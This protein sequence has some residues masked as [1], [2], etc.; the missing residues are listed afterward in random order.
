VQRRKTLAR[1]G[2]AIGLKAPTQPSRT[3]SR[4][5]RRDEAGAPLTGEPAGAVNGRRSPLNVRST[6][7]EFTVN[8]PAPGNDGN[9]IKLT[10]ST[11]PLRR[12]GQ[13]RSGASKFTPTIHDHPRCPRHAPCR[14]A[15]DE[16]VQ[17]MARFHRARAL[18]L[19]ILMMLTVA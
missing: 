3:F 8:N 4:D 5:C 7:G 9:E 10:A 1:N 2:V 12:R 19:M 15:R 17:P 16:N 14:A 6:I 11:P 18:Q 13:Q